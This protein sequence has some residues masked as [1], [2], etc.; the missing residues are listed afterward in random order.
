MT[1]EQINPLLVHLLTKKPFDEISNSPTIS[2]LPGEYGRLIHRK[3]ERIP[4]ELVKNE[5]IIKCKS[6]H[7]EGKYNV[8]LMFLQPDRV[9]GH[10]SEEIVQT[11]GYFRCKHCNDAGNWEMPTLFRVFINFQL[12]NILSSGEEGDGSQYLK[13]GESLLFDKTWHLYCSDAEEHL[14][15][16]LKKD[17]NNSLIWDRL[18]NLYW[19]G[20][21]PD[22]AAAVY[23]YALAID[24]K[25]IESHLTLGNFLFQIN[26]YEKS[27]Y[28][29]KQLLIW[30]NDYKY[31]GAEELREYI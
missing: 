5:F 3:K 17:P 21:R 12:E 27:A 22:L 23:E 18:G 16:K 7:H 6:C 11:T 30:A 4:R 1:G 26:E 10:K 19:K 20:D 8:G 15:K 24:P 14:L 28:H 29:Y 31:M 25:Q 9:E 13:I 2:S